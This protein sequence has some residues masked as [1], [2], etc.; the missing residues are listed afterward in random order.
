MGER[1]GQKRGDNRVC[2][3]RV[4]GEVQLPL[5]RVRHF[6]SGISASPRL[7]HRGLVQ[8]TVLQ[9][10]Q[11]PVHVRRSGS[12]LSSLPLHLLCGRRPPERRDNQP[13]RQAGAED[14]ARLIH[15]GEDEVGGQVGGR[16][17][18]EAA[19]DTSGLE[20]DRLQ[21]DFERRARAGA[22]VDLLP[23]RENARS[24]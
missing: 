19:E 10:Q 12:P 2:L 24:A 1:T 17:H 23:C 11:G 6:H 20:L 21:V 16:G 3:A 9:P 8:G 5:T 14:D 4:R 15:V 22:L 13:V 18:V 7:T